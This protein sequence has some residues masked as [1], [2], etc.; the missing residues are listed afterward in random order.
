MANESLERRRGKSEIIPLSE[1]IQRVL[2]WPELWDFRFEYAEVGESYS[3]RRLRA[4]WEAF[5]LA[6]GIDVTVSGIV[7]IFSGMVT[8][9]IS[10]GTLWSFLAGLG[11]AALG[12][13]L[14]LAAFWLLAPRDMDANL[15][16]AL[17]ANELKRIESKRKLQRIATIAVSDHERYL[18][19]LKA[20]LRGDALQVH[21]GDLSIGEDGIDEGWG[22]FITIQLDLWNVRNN[23]AIIQDYALAVYSSLGTFR[24]KHVSL[25]GIAYTESAPEHSF[26]KPPTL[27]L[28]EHEIP[29]NPPP[30]GYIS[31]RPQ[32]GKW[33]RFCVDGFE[34]DQIGYGVHFKD[35]VTVLDLIIIDGDRQPH[36]IRFTPPWIQ[37]GTVENKFGS[38]RIDDDMI[39]A[40]LAETYD[41][42]SSDFQKCREGIIPNE[43]WI[44]T[45]LNSTADILRRWRGVGYETEF[46]RCPE[47]AT[48]EM[49]SWTPAAKRIGMRL[50]ARIEKLAEFMREIRAV[51]R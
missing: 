24:A 22:F 12:V 16:K 37:R 31:G 2:E 28:D 19:S 32:R 33:L 5:K 51:K 1:E 20:D 45:S 15:T 30:D 11:G 9:I 25:Y 35:C 48:E 7:A 41:S 49:Q 23:P 47:H 38:D 17:A 34:F 14:T 3:R 40:I 43:E 44:Q 27:E 50:L 36:V 29:K 6:K 18:D 42:L 10:G 39:H 26:P 13:I 46:N 8:A 21:I 4:T